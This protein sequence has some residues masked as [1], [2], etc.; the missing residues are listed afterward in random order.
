MGF[1][2]KSTS[3]HRIMAN[4]PLYW[5]TEKDGDAKTAISSSLTLCLI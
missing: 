2:N 3:M 1:D 5:F 4:P